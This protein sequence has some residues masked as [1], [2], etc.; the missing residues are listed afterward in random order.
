MDTISF[1]NPIKTPAPIPPCDKG[2]KC[3]IVLT[4][5]CIIYRG[6]TLT[7]TGLKKGQRMEVFLKAVDDALTRGING[8]INIQYVIPGRVYTEG[9]F[10]VYD[11]KVYKVKKTS[12]LLS[13]GSATI[14]LTNLEF[15]IDLN[16]PVTTIIEKTQE[17]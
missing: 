10:V 17:V 7:E 15:Q 13:E 6:E 1:C 2:E 11:S 16:K 12:I 9:N 3:D 14:D 5:D 8:G 4:S